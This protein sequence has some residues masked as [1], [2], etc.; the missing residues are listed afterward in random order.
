MKNWIGFFPYYFETKFGRGTCCNSGASNLYP[1]VYFRF[2]S[3]HE[4]KVF[5]RPRP[6]FSHAILSEGVAIRRPTLSVK[7][8]KQF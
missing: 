5:F 6:A 2:K 4:M 7:P 1:Q 3:Q 8:H